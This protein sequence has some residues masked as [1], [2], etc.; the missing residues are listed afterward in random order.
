MNREFLRVLF[1]VPENE[2]INFRSD[3]YIESK[4]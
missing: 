4:R 2:D 3:P 1:F